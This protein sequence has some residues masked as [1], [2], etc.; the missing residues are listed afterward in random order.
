MRFPT[1]QQPSPGVS[2]GQD[3]AI[4]LSPA[5]VAIGDCLSIDATTVDS[6]GRW[7]TMRAVA[8]ADFV[9]AS[10]AA[11][12]E[13]FQGIALDAATVAGTKIRVLFR[14][15]VLALCTPATTAGVTRLQ[16]TNASAALATASAAVGTGNKCVAIAL[17]TNAT[18]T[19][20]KS[21]LFNGWEGHGRSITNTT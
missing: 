3:Q 5:T 10:G 4:M 14:G 17:E 8:T 19:V 20:L 16:P 11:N 2:F 1:S 21:V 9:T 12:A 18:A 15:Q 7:T 13:I 6:S